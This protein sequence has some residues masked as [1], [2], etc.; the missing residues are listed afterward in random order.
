MYR[1]KPMPSQVRPRHCRTAT[2]LYM[3]WIKCYQA[4]NLKVKCSMLVHVG[5]PHAAFWSPD[6][7]MWFKLQIW[8]VG[9]VGGTHGWVIWSGDW[10]GNVKLC[11]PGC[12]AP[13]R[14]L[15]IYLFAQ[16]QVSQLRH[17][18]EQ[19]AW[20]TWRRKPSVFLHWRRQCRNT[21]DPPQLHVSVHAFWFCNASSMDKWTELQG[22]EGEKKHSSRL[23]VICLM[24]LEFSPLWC[25]IGQ[26]YLFQVRSKQPQLGWP[27]EMVPAVERMNSQTWDRSWCFD[28]RL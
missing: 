25:H 20:R 17:M 13:Q 15:G 4:A 8:T 19:G 22:G 6:I 12:A 14:E 24:S 26:R 3:R 27:S 21:E 2:V 23:G 16:R 9:A 28:R 18:F 1:V 11:K 5:S 10:W 7:Y